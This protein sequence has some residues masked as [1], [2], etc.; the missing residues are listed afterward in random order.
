MAS[1]GQ[2]VCNSFKS[3]LLQGV[4]AFG[5]VVTRSGLA[6]D[7]FKAALYF[8]NSGLGAAT[9]AYTPTGEV[10]GTGYTAGGT[11]VPNANAPTNASGTAYWTPSGNIQWTGLTV[12]S[13]FDCYLLYNSSQANRAV[14]AFTFTPQTITAGT[15]TITMPANTASSA[16][17][18]LN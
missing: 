8:Q 1:N 11:T 17:I 13:L 7:T 6:P 3:E 9:T 14:A 16:L 4:H 10:S 18:Q 12:A 5:A 15:F 2:A